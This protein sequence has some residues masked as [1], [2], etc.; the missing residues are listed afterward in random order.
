MSDKLF[1]L[2]KSMSKQEKRYFKIFASNN[3]KN[4]NYVKLFDFIAKLEEYKDEIVK[5]KFSKENFIS[6]LHVTKNLL[7]KLILRSLTVYHAEISEESKIKELLRFVEILYH[8]GLY[9]QCVYF[10]EK[11]KK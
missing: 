10:L 6:Q 2:I 1:C 8:K 4:S 11:Q 9:D 5:E 7:H 3:R